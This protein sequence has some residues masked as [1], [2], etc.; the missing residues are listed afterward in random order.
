MKTSLV[1]A[2]GAPI[3][4]TETLSDPLSGSFRTSVDAAIR[5]IA[6]L[7][8]GAP[9]VAKEQ[10]SVALEKG[11]EYLGYN[12]TVT[13]Q[14][15]EGPYTLHGKV[16]LRGNE[17]PREIEDAVFKGT[18]SAFQVPRSASAPKSGSALITG[19]E[20]AGAITDLLP[21]QTAK[22]DTFYVTLGSSEYQ[23]GAFPNRTVAL[24]DIVAVNR[25]RPGASKAESVTIREDGQEKTYPVSFLAAHFLGKG[26]DGTAVRTN[27]GS[28]LGKSTSLAELQMGVFLSIDKKPGDS[29]I[30]REHAK[31][32]K[33]WS[34]PISLFK[35]VSVDDQAWA[36]ATAK[37][38]NGFQAF[39]RGLLPFA[40]PDPYGYIS[41]A[42]VVE[43][44]GAPKLPSDV[45]ADG[46]RHQLKA[47][48]EADETAAHETE[49]MRIFAVFVDKGGVQKQVEVPS[50]MKI[51]QANM[52]AQLALLKQAEA[53]KG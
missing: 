10:L 26:K 4:S 41:P 39:T 53:F 11:H 28:F 52:E 34:Q 20:T 15:A 50:D 37:P 23:K 49:R 5:K 25:D 43:I 30:G 6:A 13:A 44:S 19:P 35:W 22:L 27:L 2:G 9:N 1:G 7:V 46:G 51:T 36:E 47:R 8:E 12:Y 29:T 42:D 18:T 48:A 31:A 33:N 17:T 40:K 16:E 32:L 21:K 14:T 24:E 38:K 45:Y 3:L